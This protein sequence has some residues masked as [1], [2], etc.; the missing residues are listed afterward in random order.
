ME[1]SSTRQA[2]DTIKDDA[3]SLYVHHDW[4]SITTSLTDR[5]SLFS[6]EF[7]FDRVLWVSKIYKDASPRLLEA[8]RERARQKAGHAVELQRSR[9]IDRSLRLDAKEARA[10]LRVL[11]LSSTAELGPAFM[12]AFRSY[13]VLDQRRELP[14]L[15]RDR[16]RP[17][18]RQAAAHLMVQAA[19]LARRV[20][21][22]PP[23]VDDAVT[24]L[25]E[26]PQNPDLLS[27]REAESLRRLWDDAGFQRERSQAETNGSGLPP[28][29]D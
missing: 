15:E 28:Y 20:D 9:S 7:A 24:R 8:M 22:M 21:A 12:K 2:F 1:S 29:A 14:N 25:F 5:L 11:L 6:R 3:S 16:L 10:T 17:A 27:P 19:E 23:A 13:Q 26:A 18:I 4:A